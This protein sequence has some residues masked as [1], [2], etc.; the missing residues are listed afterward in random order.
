MAGGSGPTGEMTGGTVVSGLPMNRDETTDSEDV[1]QQRR[2]AAR[3]ESR[4]ARGDRDD[5]PEET[6]AFPNDHVKAQQAAEAAQA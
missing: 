1:E 4:W 6:R 3:E 5:H 2:L